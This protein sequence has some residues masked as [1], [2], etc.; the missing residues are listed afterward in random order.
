L[1]DADDEVVVFEVDDDDDDDVVNSLN[2]LVNR[3]F[4]C[5]QLPARFR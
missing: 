2:S 5:N 4:E 3:S 1:C